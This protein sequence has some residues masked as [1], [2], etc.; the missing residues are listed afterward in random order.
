MKVVVGRIV[1]GQPPLGDNDQLAS[2]RLKLIRHM[3][4]TPGIK[5]SS[6]AELVSTYLSDFLVSRAISNIL[7][8]QTT[9][10]S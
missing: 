4:T 5:F 9:D 8:K 7:I 6:K 2:Y 3:M 1:L 10:R